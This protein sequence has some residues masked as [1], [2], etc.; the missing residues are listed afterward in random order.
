MSGIP[1]TD[2]LVVDRD[3]VDEASVQSERVLS[4]TP[5]RC[6]GGTMVHGVL[7]WVTL[8]LS[9]RRVPNHS[10]PMVVDECSTAFP[11]RDPRESESDGESETS[12][13]SVSPP[14]AAQCAI[15]TEGM[16]DS[17]QP[18]GEGRAE[19]R[20]S[21]TMLG[22]FAGRIGAAA[23]PGLAGRKAQ[24]L[25]AYLLLFRDKPHRREI[26]ADTLWGGINTSQSKKYLRQA[27]WH[28][29]GA[30]DGQRCSTASSPVLLIDPDW[31]QLNERANVWLDV[32]EVESAFHAARG[33]KGEDLPPDLAVRLH[34]A[35]EL[36]RG[37]LLEG[38]YEEWC[39]FERERLKAIYLAMVE[40]MLGYHESHLQ[41][42][43]GLLCGGKI[44]R[45]DRAH[46][47]THR[48]LMRLQYLT[49]DR[50]G[51]MRQYEMCVVALHDELDV[52]PSDLTSNLYERIRAD[53]DIR[54][55]P[56]APPLG[57]DLAGGRSQSQGATTAGVG[58]F[59]ERAAD[60]VE[61][62]PG[63]RKRE[64]AWLL[65]HALTMLLG[66]ERLI[67]RVLRE[68]QN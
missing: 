51:A 7:P 50:T 34:H 45:H 29:H 16:V 56:T 23:M 48:R 19:G 43:E 58:D 11:S 12:R 52:P 63:K 18:R 67:E 38:W 55:H 15:G 68:L 59:A 37:E 33:T 14:A 60:L 22:R 2:V 41:F 36:Y 40:K 24:E 5:E 65:Q 25:M 64:V 13:A 54:S 6:W 39:V 8:Q 66:S 31:I 49:G 20:A 42:D 57:S 27:L 47:R 61:S 35:V 30:V 46:E 17:S 62:A 10:T 3:S 28:L 32:A 9:S 26:L 4:G 21:F 53:E 44:L 1:W